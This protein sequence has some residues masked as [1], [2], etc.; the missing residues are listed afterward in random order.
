MSESTERLEDELDLEQLRLVDELMDETLSSI[1]DAIGI[2]HDNPN[3][4]AAATAELFDVINVASNN[5]ASVLHDI[6]KK[7]LTSD[8]GQ[9]DTNYS[10]IA[11]L[12]T[13]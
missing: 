13:K 6:A 4:S 9:T 8:G 11:Q 1:Q 12:R 5:A 7:S 3:L 10:T 2:M